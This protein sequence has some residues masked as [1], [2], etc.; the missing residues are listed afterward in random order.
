MSCHIIV[1]CYLLAA[2]GALRMPT[3]LIHI[4]ASSPAFPATASSSAAEAVKQQ[5]A[6]GEAA[7]AAAKKAAED[8]TA[9]KRAAEEAATSRHVAER[10]ALAA[11]QAAVDAEEA[12]KAVTQLGD[13]Q[14]Q[15][16]RERGRKAAPGAARG[17]MATAAPGSPSSDW[18][19]GDRI[20][21]MEDEEE[22]AEIELEARL[23]QRRRAKRASRVT[24]A[25]ATVGKEDKAGFPWQVR[26]AA[27][28]GVEGGRWMHACG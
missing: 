16:E 26:G 17:K 2:E 5:A 14:L 4:G 28:V 13:G 22:E 25:A 11:A 12:K 27:G 9:A 18:Q 3:T 1:L 20:D 21:E 24:A 19:S 23:V 8:A 7:A 15:V 6:A 10:E